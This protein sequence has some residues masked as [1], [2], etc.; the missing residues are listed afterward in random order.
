MADHG[1][2]PSVNSEILRGRDTIHEALRAGFAGSIEDSCWLYDPYG[3]LSSSHILA[4]GSH[5]ADEV[6]K[7]AA[8]E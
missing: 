6:G 8:C 1:L 5:S 4:G 7:I 3:L 2:S